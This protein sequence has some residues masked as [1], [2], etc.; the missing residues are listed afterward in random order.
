MERKESEG[1]E[2]SQQNTE[3]WSGDSKGVDKKDASLPDERDRVS[4]PAKEN[5]R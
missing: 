3:M 5:L 4:C 2:I 1:G